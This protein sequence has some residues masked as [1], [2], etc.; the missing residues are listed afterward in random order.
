MYTNHVLL[1]CGVSCCQ[2]D[3]ALLGKRDTE[4]F[5]YVYFYVYKVSHEW[6]MSCHKWCTDDLDPRQQQNCVPVPAKMQHPLPISALEQK[7][8]L[9]I[10]SQNTHSNPRSRDKVANVLRPWPPST[11]L[12]GLRI[13]AHD[14]TQVKRRYE[15][16]FRFLSYA[17]E[18]CRYHY[19]FKLH[20]DLQVFLQI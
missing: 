10:T 18:T 13:N 4:W 14:K 19:T 5:L 15:K 12:T 1:P 7:K 6:E 17:S 11:I 9:H 20:G 2:S 16:H 8:I 3:W